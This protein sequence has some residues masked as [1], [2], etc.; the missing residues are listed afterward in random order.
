MA[1]NRCSPDAPLGASK[2]PNDRPTSTIRSGSTSGFL[3]SSSTIA[4]TISSQS[5]RIGTRWSY[6]IDP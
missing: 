3:I 1:A 2:P 4:G 6:N 5:G